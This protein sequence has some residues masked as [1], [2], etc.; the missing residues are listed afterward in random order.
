MNTKRFSI[1]ALLALLLAG[2]AS[3]QSGVKQVRPATMHKHAHEMSGSH[4]PQRLQAP[5]ILKNKQGIETTLA[6]AFPAV[7]TVK[8]Q[9]PWTEVHDAQ[10]KLL[11]YAVYSMPESDSIYG[12]AA[13][14]HVMVAFNKK[15][16]ITGVYLLPNMETPRFV[17]RVKQAGFFDRWNGLSVKKAKSMMPDAVSGATYTSRGVAQSVQAA[18]KK[19]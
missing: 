14:T 2:T 12:Y 5:P 19:L 6:Q 10:G 18:L 11:G 1:V 15:K 3:A 16:V 4:G 9:G 17:E 8:E 13:Q 7:A